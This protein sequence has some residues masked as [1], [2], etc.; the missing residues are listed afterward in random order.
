MKTAVVRENRG[1]YWKDIAVIHFKKD[2]EITSAPALS[3]LR[4]KLN[5]PPS[6]TRWRLLNGPS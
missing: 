1:A 5:A 4:P 3:M 2:G 6:S